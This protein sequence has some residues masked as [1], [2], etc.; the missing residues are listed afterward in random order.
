MFYIYFFISLILISCS[1]KEPEL[2]SDSVPTPHA[3][4]QSVSKTKAL[5]LESFVILKTPSA[6]EPLAENQLRVT[7][8][9]PKRWQKVAIPKYE[10][11]ELE[12][13]NKQM[14]ITVKDRNEAALLYPFKSPV[15]IKGISIKG[16]IEMKT[17]DEDIENEGN[18]GIGFITEG[19]TWYSGLAPRWLKREFKKAFSNTNMRGVSFIQAVPSQYVTD[20]VKRSRFGLFH[21]YNVWA[22][23]APGNDIDYSYTLDKSVFSKG[24]WFKLESNRTRPEIT[25]IINS[26][27]LT[28]EN[29]SASSLSIQE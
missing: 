13:I 18:F 14:V 3:E 5:E 10:P 9:D 19:R 17:A 24:L 28:T 26:I 21:E 22:L 2:L 4:E 7:V 11:P 29:P 8:T 1:T 27:I 25:A 6:E 16:S 15:Y 23:D 12:F 20:E